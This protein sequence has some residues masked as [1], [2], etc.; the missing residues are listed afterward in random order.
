MGFPLAEWRRSLFAF[1]FSNA[2]I[3]LASAALRAFS[4]A[5][6][7]SIRT[8]RVSLIIVKRSIR[9]SARAIRS[10]T[11]RQALHGFFAGAEF[12]ILAFLSVGTF[13]VFFFTVTAYP[14]PFTPC[15]MMNFLTY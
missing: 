1:A 2:A 3:L 12:A 9:A 8:L 11:E 6:V 14:D 7:F 13:L 4:V 5:S 15:G 10:L